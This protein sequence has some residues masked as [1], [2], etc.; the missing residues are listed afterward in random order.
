MSH[1]A[2]IIS[3][4]AMC[5]ALLSACSPAPEVNSNYDVDALHFS[6]E[7]ALELETEFVTQFPHRDSGQPN[8]QL[9]AEWLTAQF[10]DLGLECSIDEWEVINY[11]RPVGLNNVVCVLAGKSDEQ[12][13]IT[14][15]HDQSPDTIQGADNDG[16]G[17]AILLHLAEVFSSETKPYYTLVFLSSDGEEYGML[18]TRRYISTH[19][20]K[21]RIIAGITLDNLG[22]YFYNDLECVPNGQFRRY[23]PIWLLLTAQ[24]AAR[25][26][27][28]LWVPKIRA[29]VFQMLD[30]A[31]P[32]SFMDQGPVVA[33]GV[34]A[35]GFAGLQPAEFN[36]TYWEFY[37]SPLDTIDNQS[38]EILHQSG[39]VPE[40]LIRELLAKDEF[41]KESGPYLYLENG[42]QVLRG[43][44]LWLIFIGFVG[45]FFATAYFKGGT[46]NADKVTS[47]INALPHFLSLWLPLLGAIV[48]SYI[49]VEVGIMDSY[50]TYPAT[51]KDEPIFNPI[52][53]AVG[54]FLL[55]LAVFFYF[56]RRWAGRYCDRLAGVTAG[57]INSL[58]FL[59]IGL[60]AVYV[61]TQN[62]FSLLFLVPALFW[63]L[64]AGRRKLGK[65]LDIILFLLG[66]M[67]VYALIYFFGFGTLR[68]NFTVLWYL[69][70]MFS[71]Q[72]ISFVSTVVITAIVGAGLS[73]IVNPPCEE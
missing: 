59:V 71:I 1:I 73:M 46:L 28:D 57:Q 5:S 62:P 37:H 3:M 63:F 14:A 64:I 69:L 33:A 6:G 49:M 40:A 61:L 12:I 42:G 68:N 15:H 11:S 20:D 65:L 50:D 10:T 54:I 60:G 32:I 9:A 38:A 34:P 19:P 23:G 24:E 55:S 17:V 31:V 51:P 39:R 25:K 30:Q 13:L 18:G 72:E 35:L 53:P 36:E 8:N 16:S 4:I 44:H 2:C 7:R 27:G 26:A 58:A 66:G 48:V 41:P 67:V 22:N 70:M 47:W 45:L 21:K 43:L 29:P 52:W 56:G